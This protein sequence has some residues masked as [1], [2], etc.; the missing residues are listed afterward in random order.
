[1]LLMVPWVGSLPVS[2]GPPGPGPHAKTLQV[3]FWP[4]TPE[5]RLTLGDMPLFATDHGAVLPDP[6]HD[7]AAVCREDVP[8]VD[9]AFLVRQALSSREC[10]SFISVAESLGFA[11]FDR[12]K[13][14]QGALTWV[15]DSALLELLYSRCE[16]ALPGHLRADD[17]E[18]PQWGLAGLN[19]RC[20]FYRYQAN[21]HDTFKP[22]RDD[23]SPGSGFLDDGRTVM[24]WDAFGGDRSSLL[25]FLLYL[26]DD[27]EGGQTTFF[28]SEDGPGV[29]VRPC[30]GS[31]L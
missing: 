7:M 4:V 31:V 21:N 16:A 27:F 25:T 23:S 3:D 5:G 18:G 22:H 8:G 17:P 13:N 28:P 30:Q 9:G 19:Q 12:G 20:R 1:M 10:E 11:E 2:R 29:P 24:K 6:D 26:N 15:L 14:I